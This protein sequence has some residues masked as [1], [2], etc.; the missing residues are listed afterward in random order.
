MK[1][2][3]L[4]GFAACYKSAV[5]RLVADMLNCTYIDTDLAIERN[6]NMSVQQIF[7]QHGEAYFRQKE[8]QLLATLNCDNTVVACGGGSVLAPNFNEFARDSI[9]IC[10][11]ASAETIYSRLGGEVVR[12]LFDGL[13]LDELRGYIDSRAPLYCKYAHV[14]FSTDGKTPEQVAQQVCNFLQC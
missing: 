2:I 10:L 14:T 11:T 13:S 12:P 4:I 1:K 6:C 5:G 8:S 9:V 3:L 7:E